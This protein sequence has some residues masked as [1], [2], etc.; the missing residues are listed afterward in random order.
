MIGETIGNFRIA[1]KLGRGG[2]GEVFLAEHAKIGTK[3]AVKML[4]PELSANKQHVDRFFN[5][6]LAVSKIKHAGIVRIFDVGFHDKTGSAYLIMELLEG[7]S[8]AGRITRSGRLT[9]GQIADIGKQIASILDA[10]HAERVTHRDLKPDNIFLVR[11]AELA[12]GERVKILDFGIAKLSGTLAPGS[13]KTVGAMG[14]PAYM[15]PEQWGDA[16]KVDW[17]ADVYS[18]GCVAFEMACGRTPF[19]ADTFVEAFTKHMTEP[20]P[21]VRTLAPGMPVQLE[22]L[23]DQLLAKKPE[24]R[25]ATMREIADRFG[26]LGAGQ[27]L[28]TDATMLP[29]TTEPAPVARPPVVTRPPVVQPATVAPVIKP[30]TAPPEP[31]PAIPPPR[32]R[33][34]LV[35][36]LGAL[37]AT[38]GA[39]AIYL[40][41]R[42]PASAPAPAPEPV[43]QPA[44]P[45]PPTLRARVE[46]ANPFVAAGSAQLQTREISDEE[47]RWYLAS[48][49]EAAAAAR[50]V[51]P[52]WDASA[53]AQR[54]PVA[55]ITFERAQRFCAAI[56]AALPSEAQWQ[57]ARAK[58]AWGVDPAH[59]GTPGPLEEWT[60]TTRDGFGLVLGA[61]AGMTDADKQL[62]LEGP[63][64]KPTEMLAGAGAPP[65][66]IASAHIGFRCAR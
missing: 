26:A 2:M 24:D 30:V 61:H 35:L 9:L 37:A 64:L 14:T 63:M 4:L 31:P 59:T 62:A 23:I 43:A 66:L 16:S 54:A 48:L 46:Q 38:G 6:A 53:A 40:S 22:K 50:P 1:S 3:V 15:A 32:S 39:L 42:T 21:L 18:L 33:L 58:D 25:P 12:S 20:P 11:D 41:T 55:W 65:A 19:Q 51:D 29:E 17:R 36:G 13:P 52:A 49:G 56:G 34:P 28:I 7:E 45:P 10:T 5:E 8:L 27:P 60:A 57:A 47:Y 44:P